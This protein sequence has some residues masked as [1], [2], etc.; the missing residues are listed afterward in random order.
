MSEIKPCPFC[1]AIDN[2]VTGKLGPSVFT[3]NG[4]AFV[5]CV[6]CGA[7]GPMVTANDYTRDEY[8]IGRWNSR[9]APLVA[10]QAPP[11]IFA[12]DDL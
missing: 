8:V 7:R 6:Q 12:V 2:V 10:R 3:E 1:A 9:A 5:G 4:R 11:I